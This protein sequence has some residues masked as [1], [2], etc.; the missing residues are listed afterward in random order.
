M[1]ECD[2]DRL[3]VCVCE[4]EERKYIWKIKEKDAKEEWRMRVKAR[5]VG[6]A[7]S[8]VLTCFALSGCLP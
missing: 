4:K 2:C 8:P 1:S 7:E 5:D 6:V 3:S